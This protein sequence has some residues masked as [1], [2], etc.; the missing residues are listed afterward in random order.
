MSRSPRHRPVACSCRS[1][2]KPP[3][4]PSSVA[5]STRRSL[6]CHWQ[7][8]ATA[9]QPPHCMMLGQVQAPQHLPPLGGTLGGRW[10]PQQLHLW[11]ECL[12][13]HS[14]QRRKQRLAELRCQL[15][16]YPIRKE[17]QCH[18]QCCQAQLR[19][20]AV[21]GVCRDSGVLRPQLERSSHMRGLPRHAM[22]A[23]NNVRLL[24][25]IEHSPFQQT[26][27]PRLLRF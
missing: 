21:T 25:S 4:P 26:C 15:S 1:L 8:T 14:R 22:V 20:D 17:R 13:Y 27:A 3:Q 11:H 2:P 16:Q 6:L 5:P 12:R 10:G 19:P 9:C 18:T 7:S 24:E 23:A